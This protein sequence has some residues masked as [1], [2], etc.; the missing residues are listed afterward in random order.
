MLPV[1]KA[2]KNIEK[3]YIYLNCS[4]EQA[5]YFLESFRKKNNK[6]RVRLLEALLSDDGM[7]MKTA[8][9]SLNI[10]RTTIQDLEQL[11]I[12]KI[13]KEIMYRNPISMLNRERDSIILNE[14]QKLIVETIKKDYLK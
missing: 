5:S 14:E 9:Q 1:K 6:G 10:A 8:I 12:I 2:V 13:E 4:N 7:D 3:K 11:H